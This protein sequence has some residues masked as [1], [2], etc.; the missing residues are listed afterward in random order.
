MKL[1]ESQDIFI[2]EKK[3]AKLGHCNLI[4]YSACL[5]KLP[6]GREYICCL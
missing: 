2:E 4:W 1:V 6:A 3:K 5:M